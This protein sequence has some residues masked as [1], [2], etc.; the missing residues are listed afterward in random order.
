MPEDGVLRPLCVQLY[1][2]PFGNLLPIGPLRPR[3]VGPILGKQ[4][5]CHNLDRMQGLVRIPPIVLL[6]IGG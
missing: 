2:C 5:D 3:C 1:R 4:Y 6:L